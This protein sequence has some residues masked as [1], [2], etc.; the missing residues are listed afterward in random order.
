VGIIIIIIIII[1]GKKLKTVD[2]NDVLPRL[3][4][5]TGSF[6]STYWMQT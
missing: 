3:P 4:S 1:K 5:G 2:G 6:N